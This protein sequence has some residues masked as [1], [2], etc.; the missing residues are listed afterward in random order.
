[1]R[2]TNLQKT[3]DEN[4]A[5]IEVMV[6]WKGCDHPPSLLFF[7]RQKRYAG[8]LSTHTHPF[9]LNNL[10]AVSRNMR[11]V[12]CPTLS[13][14]GARSFADA[15]IRLLRNKKGCRRLGATVHTVMTN[16]YERDNIIATLRAH[17]Q[18]AL[19]KKL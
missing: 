8:F 5:A 14:N 4:H 12:C 19:P 13:E 15:G 17:I 2:L 10:D 11:A 1:M 7:C 3:V 6:E 9:L 16:R 18:S